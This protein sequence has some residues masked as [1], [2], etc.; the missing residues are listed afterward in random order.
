MLK[1]HKR[2]VV[3]IELLPPEAVPAGHAP[4]AILAGRDDGGKVVSIICDAGDADIALE[5]LLGESRGRQ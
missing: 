1:M 2:A 5:L 4:G 3:K